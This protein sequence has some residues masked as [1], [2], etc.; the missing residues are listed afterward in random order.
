MEYTYLLLNLGSLSVPF[1]FSFH[2]K[3]LFYKEWKRFFPAL[4]FVAFIFIVWDIY[5]TSIG[6]WGFNKEYLIGVSIFNLPL[7]EVLFF[8]CIPYASIFIY[9][10]FKIFFKISYPELNRK[11]TIGLIALLTMVLIFNFGKLYTTVTFT[12][13]ILLLL[14]TFWKNPKWLTVFYL[15]FIVVL[16]PFFLVNGA[17]TGMFFETPVVWYN[18]A[19]NLG[20]R[21]ISIPVED[22]VYALLM[23]LPTAFLFEKKAAN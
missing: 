22:S 14:Y 18:D 17:L 1:L 8:I 6:V 15:S 23:L 16:I 3:L 4:L 11:I 7:E 12:L 5:F 20:I 13:T 9:H 21:M 19:E 10:C 2:P